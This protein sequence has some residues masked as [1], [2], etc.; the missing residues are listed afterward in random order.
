MKTKAIAQHLIPNI[1]TLVIVGLLVLVQSAGALPTAVPPAPAAPLATATLISYQ[2]TLFDT[3]GNPISQTVTMVFSLYSAASGG[4]LLWGPETQTV[5]VSNGLFH[6]LLGSI[7]PIDPTGWT[8]NLYLDI[9]VNGEVMSPR[10]TLASVADAAR[11]KLVDGDLDMRNRRITN[12]GIG[13]AINF[14][15]GDGTGGGNAHFSLYQGD[16]FA[17]RWFDAQGEDHYS[18]LIGKTMISARVP[19]DM[20]GQNITDASRIG[21]G[22]TNPTHGIVQIHAAGVPLAFKETDTTGAGSLWRMPLDGTILRFDAS[23]NGTNFD[24]YLTPLLLYKDG[25]VG[26]GALVEANLQTPEEHAAGG[27]DRFEE[28]DVLCWGDGQLEKCARAADPLVQAVSDKG[29]RPVVIGAEPVKVIGPVKKGDFLVASA[30]P[31]YAMATRSPAFGTVIAQALED[32]DGEQGVIKA[33]I[34]KM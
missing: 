12:L 16:Q 29:G 21:V 15:I 31:G 18:F 25:S 9:T 1:G 24:S 10:E 14:S 4:T 20:H 2:G 13:S 30:V 32:F 23:Q 7:V 5:Q 8:G 6:V 28:G 19:L 34:R 3:S 27:T 22:T 33:M 11:T 17:F 26:C